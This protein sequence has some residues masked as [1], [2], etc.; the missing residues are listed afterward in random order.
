M[1][2]Q[3]VSP[4]WIARESPWCSSI[5]STREGAPGELGQFRIGECVLFEQPA[6]AACRLRRDYDMV[7]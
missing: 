5:V 6:G 1:R 7:D 2:S 3:I 4:S